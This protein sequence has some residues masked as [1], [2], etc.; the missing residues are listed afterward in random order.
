[1]HVNRSLNP[2]FSFKNKLCTFNVSPSC[3]LLFLAFSSNSAPYFFFP[4]NVV[5]RSYQF[6]QS[7]ACLICKTDRSQLA[8]E[9]LLPFLS[10]KWET[11]LLPS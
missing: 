10:E 4:L 3:P 9:I 1:M 5:A 8:T 11:K 6:F 7:Q 2:L